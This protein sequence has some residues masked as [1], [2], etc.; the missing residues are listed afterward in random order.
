M[1]DEADRSVVLAMLQ[2]ANLGK[3]EDQ[4]QGPRG[5]SFSCLSDLDAD[6]RK[7]SDHFFPTCF[8]QF[9]WDFVDSN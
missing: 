2:V 4:G 7:N 3:C 8:D 6:C 5:W 9:C 1:A